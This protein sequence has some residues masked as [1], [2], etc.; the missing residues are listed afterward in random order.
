MRGSLFCIGTGPGD[1]ELLTL[2]AARLIRESDLIAVPD[3]DS[4]ALKIA[5]GA[6][7]EIA[8]KQVLTLSMPMVRDRKALDA[9]HR[10]AASELELALDQGKNIVYLTLGDPSVYCSFTYLARLLKSDGYPFQYVSGVTSFSAAAARLG[11]PLSEGNESLHILPASCQPETA[12]ELRGTCVIMKS[13]QK[14]G[15]VKASLLKSGRKIQGVTNCGMEDE[16]V[17][18]S[19]EEIPDNAGYF[20]LLITKEPGSD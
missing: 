2:K 19:A 18:R 12:D 7:P 6:V 11:I 4:V 15:A 16:R 13:G 20:T 10:K 14:L 5:S 3:T 1:P 17:Y 9:A 8:G